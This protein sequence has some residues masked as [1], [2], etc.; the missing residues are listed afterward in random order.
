MKNYEKMTSDVLEKADMILCRRRKIRTIVTA[1]VGVCCLC[2]LIG[3]AAFLPR[4]QAG[5]GDIML[6]QPTDDPPVNE[7]PI[8]QPTELQPDCEYPI[9]PTSPTDPVVSMEGITLLAATSPNDVGTPMQANLT[10]PLNYYMMVRDLRGLTKAERDEIFEHECLTTKQ[11]VSAEAGYS[12]YNCLRRE[13]YVIALVRNGCFRLKIDDYTAVEQITIK[14]MTNYGW[15]D[16]ALSNFTFPRG[17]SVTIHPEDIPEWDQ[18]FGLRINWKY[19]KQYL[20]AL[21]TDPNLFFEGLSDTVQFAVDYKDGSRQEFF[22]CIM[23]QPD[24][25]VMACLLGDTGEI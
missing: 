9:L 23:V 16:A 10:L 24:G 3:T 22:V 13:N 20:E 17:R 15:V 1:S 19:N 14:S 5:N 11:M 18:E 6:Q 7:S 4:E 12:L 25:Q 2:L 8:Q 21:D